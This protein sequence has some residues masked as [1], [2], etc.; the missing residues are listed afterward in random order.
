M[1]HIKSSKR[2]HKLNNSS[3]DARGSV[4]FMFEGFGY[5]NLHVFVTKT[6]QSAQIQL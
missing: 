5:I 6:V 4:V 3:L 1:I 2:I